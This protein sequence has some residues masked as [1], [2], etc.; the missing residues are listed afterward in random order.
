MTDRRGGEPVDEP[1]VDDDGSVPPEVVE[2]L[3]AEYRAAVA[4][5]DAAVAAVVER[6]RDDLA[7]AKGCASCCVAGLEVLPVEAFALEQHLG[8]HPPRSAP[9]SRG[10]GACVFLDDDGA[11]LVYEARPV[12]CR[13]HGLPLRQR[14]GGGRGQ[15]PVLG[16]DVFACSLNFTE[17]APEAADVLDATT[18]M[19]LLATVDARFRERAGLEAGID[20]VPL[21]ALLDDPATGP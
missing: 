11:C 20:R 12:L 14:G 15:L 21:A 6:R 3:L 5:I 17:R 7:C 2:A 1:G 10:G 13:T 18:L 16:E 9:G 4:K 19:A 8:A